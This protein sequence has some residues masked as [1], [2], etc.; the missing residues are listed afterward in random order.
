[1]RPSPDYPP[2]TTR[3]F[4][5]VA[6]NS[7]GTTYGTSLAIETPAWQSIAVSVASASNSVDLLKNGAVILTQSIT[8][9]HTAGPLTL[10]AYSDGTKKLNDTGVMTLAG[11]SQVLLFNAKLTTAQVKAVHNLFA[12]VFS[13]SQV[14]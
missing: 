11:V 4:R 8:R 6:R 10:G 13:L 9:N 3:H 2:Q 7:G 12:P 1:M 5:L 14:A